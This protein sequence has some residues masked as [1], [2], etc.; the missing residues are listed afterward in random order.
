MI[1]EDEQDRR[2]RRPL[3][4]PDERSSARRLLWAVVGVVAYVATK[5]AFGWG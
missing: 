3:R 1:H 4:F 2:D 5:Y